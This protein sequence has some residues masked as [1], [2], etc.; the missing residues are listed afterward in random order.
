MNL[1]VKKSQ[2]AYSNSLSQKQHLLQFGDFGFKLLQN[3][4]ISEY[5]IKNLEW[6]CKKVLKSNSAKLPVKT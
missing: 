6:L 1:L 5:Q 4:R 3:L 2:K